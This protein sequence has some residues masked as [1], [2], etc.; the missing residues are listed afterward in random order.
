M[1]DDRMAAAPDGLKPGCQNVR[2]VFGPRAKD[3][4]MFEWGKEPVTGISTVAA[5]EHTPGH[6]VFALASGDA[7][8]IAMSDTTN[9]PVLFARY[10][11]WAA[12]FDMDGAQASQTRRKMPDMATT[13]RLQV[14]FY[15]AAFP[16]TG[17][18]ARDGAGFQMVPVSWQPSI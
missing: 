7:K 9:N 5:P 18:I 6:T 13:D 4:T 16:A 15:H 2:R 3:I 1:S 11:D 17:F 8:A 10:P 12:V 14:S